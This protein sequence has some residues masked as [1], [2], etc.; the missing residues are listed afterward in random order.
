MKLL[1][2]L[3]SFVICY[4]LWGNNRLQPTK[5]YS[6]LS[7]SVNSNVPNGKCLI[8][9]TVIKDGSPLKGALIFSESVGNIRSNTDGDFR[10]IVDTSDTYLV[11]QKENLPESYVEFYKFSNQHHIN[12]E[13]Y[14]PLEETT[15]M[16][17]KPVIYLYN[18]TNIDFNVNIN[19]KGDFT[20]TYPLIDNQN[21]WT[22]ALSKDG[23]MIDKKVY[24][25]IFYETK[26]KDLSF[27]MMDKTIK[28][29]VVSAKDVVTFLEQSLTSLDLNR[30]EQTDFI[31][32]WA[33]K[34]MQH[35]KVFVQLWTAND[36]N[37]IATINI[38]PTP[39][40]IQRVFMVYAPMNN[41]ME[42]ETTPQKFTPINRTGFTVIEWGGSE[43]PSQKLLL[44][45]TL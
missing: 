7:D 18:D 35:D 1:I 5:L 27:I 21:N 37:A 6:V 34:M 11:I 45:K 32:Y 10:I 36:Y 2:F 42:M 19:P 20:F 33:P 29:S 41:D 39:D 40:Q 26:M 4:S 12:L 9:G 22:G 16:V 13:V 15:I 30:K 38:T 14:I 31:T 3:F 28:G 8:T 24:P 25:Y 17:D 23:I 44:L 43:L